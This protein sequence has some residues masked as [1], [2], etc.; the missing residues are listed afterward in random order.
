MPPERLSVRTL[1]RQRGIAVESVV[2]ERCRR[3]KTPPD[4]AMMTAFSGG[5]D[6]RERQLWALR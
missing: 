2:F 1:Q 3:L 4:L 6:E 5:I